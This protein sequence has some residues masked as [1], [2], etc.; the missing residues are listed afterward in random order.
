MTFFLIGCDKHSTSENRILLVIG[1]DSILQNQWDKFKESLPANNN[2]KL[3]KKEWVINQLVLSEVQENP[4]FKNEWQQQKKSLLAKVV[5]KDFIGDRMGLTK[6]EYL[7]ALRGQ[8]R[9]PRKNRELVEE[10]ILSKVKLWDYFQGRTDLH[11]R[12]DFDI[13]QLKVAQEYLIEYKKQLKTKV[14]AKLEN[15]WVVQKSLAANLLFT[16]K[17]SGSFSLADF[18]KF[19]TALQD[20]DISDSLLK[21]HFFH[22][23]VWCEQAEQDG[24][25]VIGME[26]EQFAL[27]R[28]FYLRK[29]L[30]NGLKNQDWSAIKKIYPDLDISNFG[31]K[32][33]AF[34]GKENQSTLG[35]SPNKNPKVFLAKL[36]QSKWYLQSQILR[37]LE[38]ELIEKKDY[39]IKDSSFAFQK[40]Q[41]E[42]FWSSDPKSKSLEELWNAFYGY[43]K[44]SHRDSLHYILGQK[45]I[46]SGR[47]REGLE[48]LFRLQRL[49]PL[50]LY[51]DKVV[52]L[53]G[54]VYSENLQ[55]DTLAIKSFEKVIKLF[56]KSELV[57]DAAFM[58]KDLKSGRAYSAAF[59][60]SLKEGKSSSKLVISTEGKISLP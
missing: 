32:L 46:D 40:Y 41:Q 51:L 27:A 19:K 23:A 39:I 42:G 11:V 36:S 30:K 59:L 21:I 45:L 22:R 52:F 26:R 29:S 3:L 8:I 2:E 35:F 54:F 33:W 28:S 53:E 38:V 55:Q 50:A 4:L 12:Y 24:L 56:P 6:E 10:Y 48:V 57:D 7:E 60:K 13:D 44:L 9:S 20:V 58:I 47:Y 43:P 37:Q 34:S 17:K 14:F 15:K 16:L 18:E 25:K 1:S 31:I 5:Q 49:S